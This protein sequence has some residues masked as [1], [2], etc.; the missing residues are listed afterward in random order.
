MIGDTRSPLDG[1]AIPGRYGVADG[2]AGVFAEL[3]WP[4][5]IALVTA[6]LGRETDCVDRLSTLGVG[7]L[8]KGRAI[9]GKNCDVVWAGPG[10]Y[11]VQTAKDL[12]LEETLSGLCGDTAAVVDQ[13]DGRFVLRL[14]GSAISRCLAKGVSI[15]LHPRV[16]GAGGT[17]SLMI[18]HVQGQLTR[19]GTDLVYELMSPRSTAADLWHWLVASAGEFGLDYRASG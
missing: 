12:G 2:V 9:R 5:S 7:K 13:S 11:L 17:A 1:V 14:G 6:R 19:F 18:G 16:F 3:R 10:K 15:D 8:R 4:A